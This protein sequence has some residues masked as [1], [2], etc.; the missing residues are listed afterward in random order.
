MDLR[1]KLKGRNKKRLSEK[2]IL[3][4]NKIYKYRNNELIYVKPND[5][6]TYF[7]YTYGKK[8]NRF[9]PITNKR[10]NRIQSNRSGKSSAR[11]RFFK[12]VDALK[13]NT[14]LTSIRNGVHF[15]EAEQKLLLNIPKNR[16]ATRLT[17]ENPHYLS[18]F[19]T[20]YE[21]FKKILI[22]DLTELYNDKKY[23][24]IFIRY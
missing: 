6:N 3:F 4:N 24:K 10:I 16:K 2:L 20:S 23:N 14:R 15:D 12:F 18:D 1:I 8:T 19:Y 9:Y 17:C 5:N 21:D 7:D 22:N 13:K 11:D